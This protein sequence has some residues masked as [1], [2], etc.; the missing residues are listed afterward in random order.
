MKTFSLKGG[1]GVAAVIFAVAALI[2]LPLRT[3]QYFTIVENDGTG[4]FVAN[5]WS[6]YLLGFVL[7]VA[8]WRAPLARFKVNEKHLV[9]YWKSPILFMAEFQADWIA[10]LLQHNNC[11]N[12]TI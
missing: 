12:R 6:V 11:F 5:N 9:C 7:A 3:I 10:F 4:F 2:A 1:S 8:V